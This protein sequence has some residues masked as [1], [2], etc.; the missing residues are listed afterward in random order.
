MVVGTD[1]RGERREGRGCEECVLRRSVPS[2]RV[3]CQ[4][5]DVG[6]CGEEG[7]ERL[8]PMLDFVLDRKSVV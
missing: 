7:P 4:V 8:R 1:E 6:V 3:N 2:A 5:L